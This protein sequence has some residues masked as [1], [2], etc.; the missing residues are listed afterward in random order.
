[1]EPTA[2]PDQPK[3]RQTTVGWLVGGLLLLLFS[4]IILGWFDNT[5]ELTPNHDNALQS[6]FVTAGVGGLIS[7]VAA[8]FLLN[9]AGVI[10]RVWTAFLVVLIGALSIF[11]FSNRLA[12]SVEG[13]IDFPSGKTH[14]FP[15]LLVISRAYHTRGKGASANIQTMPTW[16]NLDVTER[17]YRFMQSHRRPGDAGRDPDEISSKGYF[18]ARVTLEQAGD[19]VRVMHAG[20][21]ALPEG[22]VFICPP[23][24]TGF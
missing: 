2:A 3:T 21:K 22:S 9:G 5:T 18:C 17:D 20:S 12:E 7:G 11:M 24:T 8:F 10:R 14:S 15:A 4:S 1:M 23:G 19:A 6:C 13:A 16:S